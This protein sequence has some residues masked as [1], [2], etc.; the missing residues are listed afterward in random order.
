MGID[1]VDGIRDII[2]DL[3]LIRIGFLHNLQT[4]GIDV[5]SGIIL[6]HFIAA[7]FLFLHVCRGRFCCIGDLCAIDVHFVILQGVGIIFDGQ[8][9]TFFQVGIFDDKT[10]PG[11]LNGDDRDTF[12]CLIVKLRI[13]FICL[14]FCAGDLIL[15]RLA[16]ST[17][18]FLK[19]SDCSVC[20]SLCND[21][22]VII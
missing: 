8:K 9:R 11:L 2:S 14:V 15:D 3:I 16:V 10:V 5:N 21:D 1:H 6:Y 19:G 12:L 4:R 17:G 22:I 7:V 20:G 13:Q 18:R